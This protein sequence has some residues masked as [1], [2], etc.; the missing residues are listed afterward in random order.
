MKIKYRKFNG[1]GFELPECPSCKITF[2]NKEITSEV[3]KCPRCGE[4]LDWEPERERNNILMNKKV[5]AI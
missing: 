4:E 3:S 1:M 5:G 2:T